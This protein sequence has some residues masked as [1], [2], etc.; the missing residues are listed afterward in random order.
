MEKRIKERFNPSILDAAIQRFGIAEEDIQL[1]D[2][3]ESYIYQFQ[4]GSQEYILRISHS[5]RRSENMIRGEV[6]W[7]NYLADGGTS[8]ARAI[9]SRYGNLVESVPDG[10]DGSFL[11][12]AFERAPGEPPWDVGWTPERYQNY[13]ALLGRMHALSRLYQPRDPVAF[14]PR[15]DD[16]IIL[17]AF[18]NLPASETIAVQKY[19]Q[20]VEHVGELPTGPDW[21][22]MIHFDAHQGN[23]FMS[24]NGDITLFDFDDC[25]YSWYANDIAVVLFYM[26]MG[27]ED[28]SAFIHEFMKDFLAGY[29]RENRF[30]TAWLD[31]FAIFLKMR[32]IDLYAVIHR[33]F[34]VDNLDDPWVA[35]YMDGRKAAIETDKP[36][37]DMDFGSLSVY[38]H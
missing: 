31:E 35:R 12:T 25:H 18:A 2:G 27:A 28:P 7:I 22:G 32:E 38:L 4:R 34:D 30:Y 19:H 8:V 37:C 15:W 6:D 1:L 23:F 20:I 26:I 21:Y 14:R 36:Y 24:Q 17:D 3:F 11:A 10:V 16:P 13:G 9:L 33:S 5:L 29:Q